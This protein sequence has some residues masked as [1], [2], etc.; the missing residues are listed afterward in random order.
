V[1]ASNS[2]DVRANFSNFG[3][4]VDLFAPGVS[5]T[6]AWNSSNTATAVLNGTSM[7][8]PHVAGVAALVLQADPTASPATVNAAIITNASGGRISNVGAGGHSRLLYSA[9]VVATPPPPNQPPTA[10]FTGSCTAL[11]C[12]FNGSGSADS[13][14]S[15]VSWAW[16]FGDGT[17]GSGATASHSYAAGGSYTVTLTVTD[18]DGATGSTSQAFTVQPPANQAPVAAFTYS[19]ANLTC[20]FNGS[21]SSDA[22]GSIVSYGWAFGDATTGSGATVSHSFAAAGTYTVVLTV[23]DDDG[24]TGSASQAVTVTTGTI[25]LTVTK[26]NVG[27]SNQALLEWTGAADTV[28]I[29]RNGSFLTRVTGTSYVD[30]RGPHGGTFT[31]QVCNAGTYVC[32][33]PVTITY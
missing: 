32:S 29:M 2:S 6:S 33:N 7:S 9:F 20:S 1:A 13:D 27:G 31:Y 24:A 4:C 10:S 22:D 19:C 15:V 5:I 28:R 21:G 17:T 11:S 26:Q 3:S 8:S 25:V 12:S 16:D 14:G 30:V 18:D 23:T